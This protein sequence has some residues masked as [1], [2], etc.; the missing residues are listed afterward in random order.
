MT[1]RPHLLQ[2]GC[3]AIA[4]CLLAACSTVDKPVEKVA[5][6][7]TPYRVELIQGN[8][9]TREQLSILRPGFT[10]QQVKDIMGTP[11][12]SSLFHAN[13]WDY[14]FTIKRQGAQPQQ[15]KLS[16]FFENNVMTRIEA[17]DMPSEAE[18]AAGIDVRKTGPTKVPRLEA[19]PQELQA[20]KPALASEPVPPSAPVSMDYPPLESP[21]R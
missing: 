10:R 20:F 15:R 3:A 12:I 6:L 2:T 19:T 18:F 14:A 8:V 21:A 4:A 11:L 16:V 13:R 9:V 17:D 5:S 1:A 7:F